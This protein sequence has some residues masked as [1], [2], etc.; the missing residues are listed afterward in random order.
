[1]WVLCQCTA[2]FVVMHC[3]VLKLVPSMCTSA[4]CSESVMKSTVR[5]M[6]LDVLCVSTV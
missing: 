5:L 4:L 3:T 2:G 1:M 6:W